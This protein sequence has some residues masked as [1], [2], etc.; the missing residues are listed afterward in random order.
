M[1]EKEQINKLC[2]KAYRLGKEYEKAYK[3]C[4]Q[5][6]VGAVQDALKWEGDDI[7]RATTGLAGGI[8][9]LLD[10]SCGAYIGGVI[11]IGLQVGREKH[12]FADPSGIRWRTYALVQKYHERFMDQYGSVRCS[13]IQMKKFGRP[14]F[15]PDKDEFAKFEEAGGHDEDGCPELVGMAARWLVEL[16]AGEDLLP[17]I[18]K[19][20]QD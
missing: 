8:G 6:L 7:F 1:K 19:N 9:A 18:S 20:H 3:G 2:K 15:L 13:D 10:G 4:G 16:L 5:C 11:L 14:Y 17:P 12:D